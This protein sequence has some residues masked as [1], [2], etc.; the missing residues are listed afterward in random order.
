MLVSDYDPHA[1][2]LWSIYVR[3]AESHNR[4]LMET[5]R[6][7]MNSIIIFVRDILPTSPASFKFLCTIHRPVFI[8][9]L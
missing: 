8:L 2:T 6:D 5:W 1:D 4:A 7:D 3:E 9:Q